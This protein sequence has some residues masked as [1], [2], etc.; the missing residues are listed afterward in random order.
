MHWGG[1]A[2]TL[3]CQTFVNHRPCKEIILGSNS[4][5]RTIVSEQQERCRQ[6]DPQNWRIPLRNIPGQWAHRQHLHLHRVRRRKPFKPPAGQMDLIPANLHWA[7]NLQVPHP[8]LQAPARLPLPGQG[9]Q[10]VQRPGRSSSSSWG[11]PRITRLMMSLWLCFH[12]QQ[13]LVPVRF[14]KRRPRPL[15]LNCHHSVCLN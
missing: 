11:L 15:V 9:S 3:F 5:P 13:K 8:H 2:D 6:A 1:G 10:R 4:W 7:Q 12:L 14:L